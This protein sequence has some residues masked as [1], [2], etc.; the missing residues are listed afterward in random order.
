MGIIR[1]APADTQELL[2]TQIALEANEEGS[3]WNEEEDGGL[4]EDDDDKEEDEEEG[5]EEAEEEEVM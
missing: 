5:E 4:E 2:Q 3:E 1:S